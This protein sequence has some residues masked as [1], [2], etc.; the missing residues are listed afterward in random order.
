[1]ISHESG[2]GLPMNSVLIADRW[3]E[4]AEAVRLESNPARWPPARELIAWVEFVR[5][6]CPEC[7]PYLP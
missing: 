6:Q 7:P 5:G 2:N 3:G 4:I 1:M